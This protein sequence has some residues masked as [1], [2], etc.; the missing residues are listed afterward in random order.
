MN[1]SEIRSLVNSAASLGVACFVVDT[2]RIKGIVR[3]HTLSDSA[4]ILVPGKGDAQELA[5]DLNTAIAPV[6]KKWLDKL[7]TALRIQAGVTDDSTAAIDRIYELVKTEPRDLH[8]NGGDYIDFVCSTLSQIRGIVNELKEGEES[9][10][11][12]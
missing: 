10:N 11:E 6:L 3:L 8:M 4:E 1:T 9:K 2:E 5:N 7:D 12:K